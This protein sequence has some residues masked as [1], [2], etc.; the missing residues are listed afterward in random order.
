MVLTSSVFDHS[1]SLG[2][3]FQK[4]LSAATMHMHPTT[5]DWLALQSQSQSE[6]GD[7]IMRA[8]DLQ[9]KHKYLVP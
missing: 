7:K 4:S 2:L 8:L 3:G 5:H 9:C 1:T 6:Q